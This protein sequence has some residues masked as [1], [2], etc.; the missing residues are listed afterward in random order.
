MQAEEL[1]RHM[2]A[3]YIVLRYGMAGL[4]ILLPLLLWIGGHVL[5]GL[6]LQ[7][8]MSAYYHAGGGALRDEF[9]GI[10]FAVA[11]CLCLYRG[12]TTL[13]NA[14]LNLAGVLAAL[15]AIFPMTWGCVTDCPRWTLHGTLAVLF[16]V[17]I[18]YVCIFR[19]SD[20]LRLVD[21]DKVGRYERTYRILGVG[22]VVFPV[23]AAVLTMVLNRESVLVFVAEALGVCI[24]ASYWLVKSHEIWA[25]NAEP[26]VSAGRLATG[27]YGARDVFKQISVE[28]ADRGP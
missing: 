19:A 18:A 9:V 23:I 26:L 3:T 1:R 16:F 28:Y 5:A 25:T 27:A 10:L 6:P 4:A 20:T 14:A 8:S 12:F 24:F 21:P 2:L 22:M 17:A 13:E 11:A 15:V 7:G